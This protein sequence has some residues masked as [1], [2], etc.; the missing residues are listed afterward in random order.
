MPRTSGVL[1]V[2]RKSRQTACEDAVG[3]CLLLGY[4][5][6]VE[7]ENGKKCGGS[8]FFLQ[9]FHNKRTKQSKV[10]SKK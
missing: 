9:N 8:V 4:N 3:R 7:V 10:K 6:T 1:I 2:C 5:L